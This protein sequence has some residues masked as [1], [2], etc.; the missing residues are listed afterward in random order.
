MKSEVK[1]MKCEICG[2]KKATITLEMDNLKLH[3]CE[4]CF[5]SEYG[6]EDIEWMH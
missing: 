3:L 1:I 6:G 4:G 5:E 2:V